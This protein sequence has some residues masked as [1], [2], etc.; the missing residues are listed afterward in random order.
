MKRKIY[1]AA[2]LAFVLGAPNLV[3]AQLENEQDPYSL[4]LEELMNIPINSASKRDET[5]FDAPLSSYTITRTDI[6][7]AGSTSIMEALRLAP[8]VI[9]RE[10]TNGNYDIHIRGFDNVLRSGG[11]TDKNSLAM[12]VMIDNRPVFNHNLGG[13]SWEILPVDIN[14][15]ERI[16]IV[17]GPSAPLFGPNAVTGVINIITKKVTEEHHVFASAQYG[18]ENTLIGQASAGKQLNDKLALSA[19][20]NFANRDRFQKEYFSPMT[21][22]YID[23]S[24]SPTLSKRFPNMERA[25]QKWGANAFVNYKATENIKFDLSVGV[26]NSDAQKILI[27]PA[28]V[29]LTTNVTETM[30]ANLAA[31]LHGV[32]IRT[33]YLD[34]KDQLNVGATPNG[35]DYHNFDAVAEYPVHVTKKIVL[36][37][38]VAYQSFTLSDENYIKEGDKTTGYLNGSFSIATTAAYLRSDINLS[39]N[40]RLLGGIRADHF[41]SSDKTLIAYEVASTYKIGEAHLVRAAVTKSNAGAF[42]GQSYANNDIQPSPGYIIHVAGNPGYKPFTLQMVEIGYRV[43]LHRSVHVDMDIFHQTGENF[44]MYVT[45]GFAPSPPFPP[46]S[47]TGIEF[48]NIPATAVQ[49]GST[50]SLNIVPNEKFQFKPFVTVQRTE[51]EDLPAMPVAPE[52][53]P[54]LP[55]VSGKSTNT[56]SVY[57]GYFAT[58]KLNQKLF[59]N[60]NGYFFASHAQYDASDTRAEGQWAQIDSK[61]L[62]NLKVNYAPVKNVNVFVNGRNILNQDSRE[63]FGTDKTGATYMLGASYV[64]N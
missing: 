47:P 41:S 16:E 43:K 6:L 15:V 58:Y 8:G 12:L 42:I 62:V 36:T 21:N 37:P 61:M 46:G 20:F 40:W 29:P 45:T 9:V 55:Y 2:L 4:S 24:G 53:M 14:D 30:Y 32:S 23:V 10:Q 38:G 64:L 25:M 39:K 35:N 34:G 7:Q 3:Q 1:C 31:S 28:D 63:F 51:V 59:F 11:A 57:G 60:L 44:G 48:Q 33:S 27:G 19:S 49:I 17:R 26:Q 13:T 50:F 5:L 54:G 18:T 52:A 22:S 56:P